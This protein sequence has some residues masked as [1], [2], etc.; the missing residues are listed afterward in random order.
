MVEIGKSGQKEL[1]PYAMSFNTVIDCFARSGEVDAEWRAE[2]LLG[3]MD[4]LAKLGD[5]SEPDTVSR[6]IL[7][8]Q[9]G[10]NLVR[11]MQLKEQKIS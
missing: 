8:W 9:P 11:K 1:Q 10:P 7:F 3:K 2:E 5:P 4:E 6:S